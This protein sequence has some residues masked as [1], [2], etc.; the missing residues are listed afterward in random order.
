MAIAVNWATKVIYV[1]KVDTVLIQAS[2]IEIREL[3]LNTFRL[4]LKNLED[5]EEGMPFLDTHQHAAP[6]TVGGVELARVVE[7][8]NGYTITFEDGQYA[9][10]LI[11]ANSNVGDNVNVNQV[12]IRSGNSAGLVTSAAIEFGEYGGVV[13]IDVVNGESGSIYPIGTYRRPSNN[14]PDSRIIAEARGFDEFYVV[15]NITISTGDLLDGYTLT[16]QNPDKT[17]MSLED[18]AYITNCEFRE[19]TI[20][21]TLDGQCLISNCIIYNL[22]Y[23]E[24]LILNCMLE[25]ESSIEL[26]GTTDSH[27]L[28]CKSGVVGVST[29]TIDMGGSGRG[30]GMRGYSGGIKLINKTGSES[31]SVDLIAGQVQLDDTVTS[32]TIVVRGVGHITNDSTATVDVSALI[33]QDLISQA[34]WD[35][36]KNLHTTVDTF[37][38]YLDAKVS[39]AGGGSLTASGIAD[40]VWSELQANHVDVGSFGYYLDAKV[41]EAGGGS[42]TVSGISDAV[43]D[44]QTVGHGGVGTF[45][46]LIYD[47]DVSIDAITIKLP[48]GSLAE[49]GE[50]TTTLSNI[51]IYILRALGLMQEDYYLDQITYT[52]YQG[53][54]LLTSGRIRTYS[55]AG[56]VGTTNDV[57]ATYQIT[58]AWSSDELTSY[59]VVKI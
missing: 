52:N 40:S 6:V 53:I 32:G 59:K 26:A 29:P 49:A 3:D 21:G 54:K 43:W 20:T 2:P 1:P 42:L 30:L 12:S 55:V 7:I 57:I 38:L 35:A 5:D 25:N 22:K 41:S 48:S 18:P 33:S 4:A 46:K 58:A 13:T 23:V 24:G 15:G 36:N 19:A 9:V 27:F 44:E 47:M 17:L 14:I 8:I 16:G 51:E 11:G 31:V 28:D 37:G 45:G 10:N 50:Y 34:V 56:S 39:E